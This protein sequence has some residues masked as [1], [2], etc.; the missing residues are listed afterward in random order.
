MSN[1]Y[2]TEKLCKRQIIVY[3][4]IETFIKTLYYH[5]FFVHS[6]KQLFLIY[7]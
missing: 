3:K 6:D 5:P 7:E 2:I 1:D 4:N